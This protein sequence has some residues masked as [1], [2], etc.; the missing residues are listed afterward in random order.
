M[1]HWRE[2]FTSWNRNNI[3]SRQET[4]FSAEPCSCPASP[5][6]FA[7]VVLCHGFGSYDDD[8]GGFV[9]LA[10][11][12]AQ[13]GL[14]SFRFSF[15]GSYPYPEKGTIQPAS[16]WINDALGALANVG[17]DSRIDPARMGLLG[18]SV[19]GGVVIQ[20]AALTKSARAVVALAPVA[21]GEDWLRYRWISTRGQAAWEQFAAEVEADHNKCVMGSVS[22]LVDQFDIQSPGDRPGWESL[23]KRYP[24]ILSKMSLSSAWDTFHFKPLFYAQAVAQPLCVVQGDAD[25]SVPQ[26]HSRL[27][28]QEARG[29]KELNVLEG[30]PHCPWE[31]PHESRFQQIALKWFRQW[32]M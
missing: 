11:F 26:K 10:D 21:D 13:Q 27:L 19:G 18:V 14:A 23:L 31:T 9:R 2:E 28:H 32:L 30:A 24:R 4:R 5:G 1:V 6:P 16:K 17:Q 22:R 20:A 15:T 25:E 7:C 8:L 29:P 3:R 12:F